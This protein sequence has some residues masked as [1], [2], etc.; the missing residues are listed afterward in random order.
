MRQKAEK[1]IREAA[2][3]IGCGPFRL[4]A[5]RAGAGLHPRVFDKTIIDMARV[6]AI[7]LAPLEDGCEETAG[8][9]R[10]GDRIYARF[11]FAAAPGPAPSPPE[12]NEAP[13]GSK[14]PPPAPMDAVVV[15]LR[16]LL[17]GE[18]EAF[19]D[20]CLTREGKSPHEKIEEMIRG[21]LYTRE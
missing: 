9:V 13:A 8:L 4:D 17:P 19:S 1:R 3:G 5:V 12:T 21:H 2:A 16:N 6:G 10:R 15:I 7:T 14:P 20:R 18:W 11:D